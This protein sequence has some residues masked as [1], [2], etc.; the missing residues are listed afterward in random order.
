MAVLLE[1]AQRW[2]KVKQIIQE[3]NDIMVNFSDHA[4]YFSAFR[5]V[6]KEDQAVL[7]SKNHPKIPVQPRTANAKRARAAKGSKKFKQLNTCPI[8]K[9]EKLYWKINFMAVLTYWL[10]RSA[11]HNKRTAGFMALC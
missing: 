4:R 6:M 7:K 1:R 10:L 3:D 2:I 11:S 5:Y 9:W 8:V